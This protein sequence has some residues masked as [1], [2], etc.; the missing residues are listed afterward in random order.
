MR[1]P[2]I[3]KIVF[4]VFYALW[5][6]ALYLSMPPKGTLET[7]LVLAGAAS[8]TVVAYFFY[9]FLIRAIMRAVS[10]KFGKGDRED[11]LVR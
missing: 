2:L 7:I 11:R 4:T 5:V 6:V 10:K 1:L 3:L 8:I 9:L